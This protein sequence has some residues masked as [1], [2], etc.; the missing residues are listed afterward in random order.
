MKRPGGRSIRVIVPHFACHSIG[1]TRANYVTPRPHSSSTCS[2]L[3]LTN[4]AA[5]ARPF[6][7]AQVV[8]AIWYSGIDPSGTLTEKYLAQLGLTLPDDVRG[9]VIRHHGSLAFA[10]DQRMP[11]MLTLLRDLDDDRPVAVVRT[12]LDADARKVAQR[13]LGPAFRAA[14]MFDPGEHA[15]LNVAI[16]IDAGIRALA[17]SHRPLWAVAER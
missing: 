7:I 11:G 2:T 15:A 14:A 12:Y 6:D 16:G 5:T 8:R 13:I 4:P 1:R 10:K 3:S 17:L 9:R